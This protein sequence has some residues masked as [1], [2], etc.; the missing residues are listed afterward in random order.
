[1]ALQGGRISLLF[2]L[3]HMER[4]ME[5][6]TAQQTFEDRVLIEC[7][8]YMDQ[9][10]CSLDDALSDWEGDSPSGGFGLTREEKSRISGEI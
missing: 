5:H 4:D 3:N 9:Y 7:Q 8:Q 10:N 1:M 2:N 6:T